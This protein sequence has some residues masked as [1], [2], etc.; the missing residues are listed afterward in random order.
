MPFLRF[1]FDSLYMHQFVPVAHLEER[2]A[3][4]GEA[5]GSTPDRHMR[6]VRVVWLSS[7]IW[8]QGTAV[9]IRDTPSIPTNSKQVMHCAVDAANVGSNPA[10]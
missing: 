3:C 4:N 1:G 5:S 10:W 8:N 7:L 6:S 9:Q 2:T